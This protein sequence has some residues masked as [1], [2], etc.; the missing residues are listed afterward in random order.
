NIT[1]TLDG[2]VYDMG[3]VAFNGTAV[4]SNA[5][6]FIFDGMTITIAS[7][8]GTLTVTD[9]VDKTDFIANEKASESNSVVL[10]NVKNVTVSTEVTETVKEDADKNKIRYY[11]L[12]MT[13]SGA[14]TS[15]DDKNISA[16]DAYTSIE[17]NGASAGWA[18]AKVDDRSITIGDITAGKKVTIKIDAVEAT[19][20]GTIT[21]AAD[22][23]NMTIAGQAVDVLG[24]IINVSG[25]DNAE[26]I[27][28]DSMVNASK[29]EVENTSASAGTITTITYT[30]FE[31][32]LAASADDSDKVIEVLG[33]SKIASDLE[34]PAGITVDLA[35][36]A[37]MTIDVD[38][39]LTVAATALLDA[40]AGSVKV[41]G[42]LVIMDKDTGLNGESK[43]TYQVLNE[44]ET[45]ATYRGLVLALQNAVA[46]DVITLKQNADITKSVTIPEGVTLVVPKNVTL[47]IGSSKDDVTLTVAGTLKVEGTVNEKTTTKEI[48]I[49]VP[50]VIIKT[51][52]LG[53]MPEDYV[54]FTMKI[55]GRLTTVYSNLAYAAANAVDGDVKVYGD[56]SGGDVT[57]TVADK[58]TLTI[59][60]TNDS[61]LSVGTLTL[62]G[63]GASITTADAVPANDKEAGII[64]GTIAAAAG[65]V[66]LNKVY[67]I[68]FTVGVETTVDASTDVVTIAGTPVGSFEVATGIITAAEG[69]AMN[70]S[71][72]NKMSV[73]SGATLLIKKAF[74]A[75]GIVDA[76]NADTVYDVVVDGTI[77]VI[78]GGNVTITYTT[79]N[80]TIDVAS[81]GILNIASATVN[82]TISVAEKTDDADAGKAYVNGALV[83]GAAPALGA[84]G[85]FVG[86]VDI[87]NDDE[88]YIIAYAGADVSAALIDVENGKSTA[89]STEIVINGVPYMTVY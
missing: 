57:F 75:T 29:V 7:V 33:T 39:K 41:D 45:T 35:T 12:N 13:V 9:K 58:K 38:G 81:K 51:G 6:I 60:V 72:D 19:V 1:G 73:A 78:E 87:K 53:V 63:A 44:T 88:A 22:G 47:S 28:I 40:S 61:T 74:T 43:L 46:G 83:L 4:G 54:E 62:V 15:I 10:K 77:S 82:G 36:G 24:S 80:G 20:A 32:A 68:T 18:D 70:A 52:T 56:I 17:N 49:E 3:T 27:V 26:E 55:D 85:A 11:T 37:A 48:A 71:K 25:A 79:V 50:G 42:M 16:E 2:A 5:K 67:G 59:T 86:P 8:A 21:I 89:K 14:V 76:T 69:F 31:A 66:D 64:T 23:S 84:N 34:V 30:T 65:S